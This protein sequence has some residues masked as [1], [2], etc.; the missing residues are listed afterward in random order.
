MNPTT[1]GLSTLIGT[2]VGAGMFGL[3]YVVARSGL[4]V[5]L[6]YFIIL[7]V[8]ITYL[9]LFFGEV[10]LRTPGKH[11]LIGYAGIYLGSLGKMV[12]AFSTIAGTI[13]ALLA[14]LIIGGDFLEIIISPFANISAPWHHILFWLPLSLLVGVGIRLIAKVELATTVALFL[15]MGLIFFL[16]LP[17]ISFANFSLFSFSSSN[18]FLPYGVILFSL[19]GWNAIPEIAEL[20]RKRQDKLQ[21]DNVIV[22]ASALAIFLYAAFAFSVVGVSGQETTQEGLSGLLPFLGNGV[23]VLGAFFGL[24]AVGDSFLI[25]G[26]YLKNSFLHDFHMPAKLSLFI[27]AGAPLVLYLVGFRE[28]VSVISVVGI[29]VGALEGLVIIGLFLQARTK[30]QLKPEYKVKVPAMVPFLIAFVLIGG[31]IAALASSL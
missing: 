17:H 4:L 20:F 18:I 10:C 22:I 5:A 2:I 11:R 24:I 16:A 30:G 12:V 15:M 13:G 7:G 27:T 31:T 29:I 3:P 28:F 19:I 26:S 9:H 1:L 25:M 6:F 8:C 21:F 23:I 14:F